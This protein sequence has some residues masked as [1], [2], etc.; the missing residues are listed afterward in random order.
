[1]AGGLG[2]TRVCDTKRS[3]GV[4]VPLRS[5][6]YPPRSHSRPQP[7]RFPLPESLLRLIS[8]TEDFFYSASRSGHQTTPTTLS[9][10]T[11]D[12]RSPSCSV[13]RSP[14]R[15][16]MARWVFGRFARPPGRAG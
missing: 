9:R 13:P 8:D 12:S 16:R 5:P 3:D 10:S 2:R 15:A 11:P 1:M 4:C 14:L 6:V 7:G